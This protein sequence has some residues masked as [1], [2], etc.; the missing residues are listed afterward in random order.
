MEISEV[1]AAGFDDP[2]LRAFLQA[3]L[4]DISPTAPACSRHALDV[5][6]LRDPRIRFWL[7]RDEGVILGTVALLAHGGGLGELKSMRTEPARRG[8]GV[9][10][11]LLRHVLAVARQSGMTRVSLETGSMDFF[12]AARR[13]YARH[14]FVEC[15]PFA[16]YAPDS[17]S[18]FMTLLL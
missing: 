12:A 6:G 9:G 7:A 1:A 10:D 15:E 18:T 4:D 3:H 16:D 11:A 8:E 13:L 14:G 17:N 5:D 2:A